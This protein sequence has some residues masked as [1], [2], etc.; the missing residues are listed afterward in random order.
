[1]CAK[2]Y[3]TPKRFKVALLQ[4]VPGTNAEENLKNACSR[5]EEAAQQGAKLIC[6]PEL[7][8]SPYFC[9]VEDDSLF[10]LAEAVP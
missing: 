9:Q 5:I 6:L 8:L 10:E 1:M 2:Q 3:K 7:F 4:T